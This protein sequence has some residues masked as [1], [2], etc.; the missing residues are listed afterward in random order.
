MNAPTANA[1]VALHVVRTLQQHG[2]AAYFAGGCVRDRIRGAAP[3]DY[4]VATS[5]HP[6]QVLALFP[7]ARKVGAAFGVMLVRKADTTIEV[8]TFRTDGQYHDGRR[9]DAV[10][11]AT[12]QEDAHRRDF[13]CNGI[14]YDPLADV[15]HDFV[16]GR[17]D[18][19]NK[20]L[21]AIGEP[22]HR[23]AE[24][25]LRMLRAVRFA[26]RLEF[27]I[28]PATFAAIQA[29]APQLRR[30][31]R[32]RTGEELRMMLEHPR[33][34]DAVALLEN[35]GLLDVAWP[36]HLPRKNQGARPA[37]PTL[38]AL[39][40]GATYAVALAALVIDAAGAA[41]II[42]AQAAAAL[43]D[44]FMLSNAVADDAQWLLAQLPTVQRWPELRDAGFK[45]LL[46]DARFPMLQALHDAAIGHQENAEELR[47]GLRERI[48]KIPPESIAPAH[49]VTGDDLINMGAKPGA[50]FRT[51][52]DDLYSQQLE[53][54]FSDRQAALTAARRLISE[55]P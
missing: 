28:D 6:E 33:R 15:Y 29:H 17:A 9:P 54:A 41:E 50:K 7:K 21:R 23:F 40:D 20:L 35:A 5:A 47:R 19:A 12:A 42:P 18:I 39:P 1:D 31:T 37:W 34:A 32:E 10:R 13:T 48:A 16:E 11:F 26:V 24:D 46:A 14:F 44:A 4:D 43:R 53:N 27:T 30:I 2:H 3:N 45:R 8:A 38:A 25:H 49:F 52:L 36:E 55:S 51:W 22:A